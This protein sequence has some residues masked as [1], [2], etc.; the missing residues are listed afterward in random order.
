MKP[1]A[2]ALCEGARPTGAASDDGGV[3][4]LLKIHGYG[5]ERGV[6][7]TWARPVLSQYVWQVKSKS[8]RHVYWGAARRCLRHARGM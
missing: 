8:M 3:V 5:V 1:I 6:N 7:D 2:A 4:A